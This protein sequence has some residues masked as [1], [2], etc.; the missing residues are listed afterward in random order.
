VVGRGRPRHDRRGW[1][2]PH[3][4]ARR[5]LGRGVPRWTP[6]LRGR[7][8]PIWLAVFP[9]SL[10]S[11][12]VTDAGLMFVRMTL[13]GRLANILGEGVL[14]EDNWAALAPE[15]LWPLWGAALGAATLAY[16]Y[17]RRGGCNHCGR[18]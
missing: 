13:T 14:T 12:L 4:R 6:L 1:R 5:A 18:A 2:C 3:L 10:V 16:Y 8:V 17:R 7:R 9:A 15:L 11:I